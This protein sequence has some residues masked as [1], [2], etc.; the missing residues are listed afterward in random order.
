MTSMPI[1]HPHPG[2]S[3]RVAWRLGVLLALMILMPPGV[4]AASKPSH[5]GILLGSHPSAPANNARLAL[6]KQRSRS[7]PLLKPKPGRIVNSLNTHP[8]KTITIN[9][10]LHK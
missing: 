5:P 6:L 1:S 3:S 10:K 4:R 7:V 2:K 8:G 9:R